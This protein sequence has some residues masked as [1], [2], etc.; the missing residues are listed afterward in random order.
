MANKTNENGITETPE[1]IAEQ[2]I[3]E[4]NEPALIEISG[5]RKQELHKIIRY[6]HSK[7]IFSKGESFYNKMK[8]AWCSDAFEKFIESTF[9]QQEKTIA[10][11][12][13]DAK[14]EYFNLLVARGT[15]KTQAMEMAGL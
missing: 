2:I 8:D 14:L 5:V 13:S 7:E 9:K 12:E 1:Q 4:A 10:K 11:S 3:K 6:R 15:P